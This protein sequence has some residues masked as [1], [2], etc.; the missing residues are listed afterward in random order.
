MHRKIQKGKIRGCAT[1]GNAVAFGDD[2]LQSLE[3][4]RISS[5]QIEAAR[6]AGGRALGGQGKY[7]VR[8]FPH[9][10]VSKKPAET[11]M[12]KGKGE[13]EYWA[14]VVK[15][16][17]VMFEIGGVDEVMAREAFRRQAAKLPV[18]CKMVRRRHG[19]L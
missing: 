9:L 18:R 5:K 1:R 19:A 10:S 15:P 2:G 17:T 13:V 11:R 16:G 4:A 6:V 8:I 12:G 7:W 14:A 3:R